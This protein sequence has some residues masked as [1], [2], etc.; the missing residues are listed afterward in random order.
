MTKIYQT[1][2]T[3]LKIAKHKYVYFIISGDTFY[4]QDVLKNIKN[5]HMIKT[6]LIIGKVLM[7][8]KIKSNL[9]N[10]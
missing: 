4:N 10:F 6:Q 5:L 7:H 3:R 1:H 2:S 8:G 9:Q